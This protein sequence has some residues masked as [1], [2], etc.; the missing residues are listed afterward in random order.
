[1]AVLVT[2]GAGYIG[3][4][5]LRALKKRG[6]DA[7]VV[8]N[9][10][11]GHREAVGWGRFYN[12]DLT[13]R[14]AIQ[15][16]FLNEDIESVIH[17]AGSSLVGESMEDPGKYFRN[18]VLSAMNLLETMA[19]SRVKKIVFS[20]SAA[21]YGEPERWPILEDF[22]AE[23]TNPY[24]ES[25]L[26]IEKM[27]CWY[28]HAFSIRSVALRY[29][30][31][32]GAPEDGEIG[33]DHRPETHLIPRVLQAAVQ[34]RT[35]QV[36]G[37]DYPTRDGTCIRDYVHVEDL[38]DAHLL[39]LDYLSSGGRTDVFNLGSGVGY[40]VLE[41]IRAA[42]QV[43][44]GYID[45][46]IVGRRAGDPAVLVASGG[47]AGVVL[48]WEPRRTSIVDIIGSAYKWHLKHPRGY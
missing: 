37:N 29:F 14:R 39:A 44:G 2:G 16:M 31:V 11:T 1:M 28:D 20:S 33:E 45:T 12:I 10:S 32:A 7:V 46:R 8:D 26:M 38:I 40:S 18:N 15:E 35:I 36:F 9:L 24:G 25:K 4:C 13:D 30:N 21:V 22:P 43:T 41:I 42:E 27:L 48:G 47:R 19:E 34:N 5:C 23:P 6:I 17:F 3:S